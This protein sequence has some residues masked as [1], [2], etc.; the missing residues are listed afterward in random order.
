M[1]T[2]GWGSRRTTWPSRPRP[3]RGTTLSELRE[4]DGHLW[5]YGGQ[6]SA[7]AGTPT[8][9]YVND[10]S[11]GELVLAAFDRAGDTTVRLRSDSQG[12]VSGSSGNGLVPFVLA[13]GQR[14]AMDVSVPVPDAVLLGYAFYARAD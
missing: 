7:R 11:D 5:Q 1:P 3:W 4:Q 12:D 6:V 2:S 9:S 10:G 8:L 14:A 13:P